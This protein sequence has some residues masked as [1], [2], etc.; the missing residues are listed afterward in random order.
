MVTHRHAARRFTGHG[1]LAGIATE[2]GDAVVDPAQRRLLI[3][4]A[5]VAD[6][7]GRTERGMG[8]EA[9]RTQPVV[10]RDD[11]DIALLRQPSGV[12][13]VAAAI[14]E[15]TAVDPH[16][17]R[18]RVARRHACRR[19]PY[20]EG[21]AVLAGGPAEI[22][23][24]RDVLDAAGTR[25]GRITHPGP[26]GRRSRRLPSQRPHRGCRV[27]N[28]REQAVIR[29]DDAAHGAKGGLHQCRIA[30]PRRDRCLRC[31]AVAAAARRGQ[32]HHNDQRGDRAEASAASRSGHHEVRAY[33]S[34][35]T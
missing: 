35:S 21:Q 4:Q 17:H 9:E 29:R 16:H 19:R 2:V 30:P 28:A 6:P 12:V 32:Q 34:G 5:I 22:G 33:G 13:D 8:K 31:L 23:I 15:G 10:D 11:D 1:H 24:T 14:E 3:G 27:R 7:A 26:R 20:V 18:P 25:V